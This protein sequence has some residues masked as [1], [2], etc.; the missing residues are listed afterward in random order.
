MDIN[1]NGIPVFKGLQKP[2]EFMGISSLASSSW[3]A[4]PP[5]ESSRSTSSSAADCTVR[6]GSAATSTIVGCMTISTKIPF[7]QDTKRKIY[8]NEY[9]EQAA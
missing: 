3:S 2:L 5:W 8:T 6:N 4:S 7:I 9:Q 1:F